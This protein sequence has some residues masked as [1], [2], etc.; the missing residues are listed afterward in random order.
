[1]DQ[2]YLAHIPHNPLEIRRFCFLGSYI[3]SGLVAR[4]PKFFL[5]DNRKV[6]TQSSVDLVHTPARLKKW[7]MVDE[8]QVVIGTASSAL[9]FLNV[10]GT[11]QF[12]TELVPCSVSLVA[13]EPPDYAERSEQVNHNTKYQPANR[14]TFCP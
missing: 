8:P 14:K 4:V 9:C 11:V 5:D 6:S 3:D 1:M 10:T 13:S 12:L 7:S 2:C